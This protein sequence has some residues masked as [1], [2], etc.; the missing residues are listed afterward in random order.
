ML[1][2]IRRPV[3]NRPPSVF[4]ESRPSR[5][6]D[7]LIAHVSRLIDQLPDDVSCAWASFCVSVVSDPSLFCFETVLECRL[8]P[9][10]LQ[11]LSNDSAVTFLGYLLFVF[12]EAC[13][14]V[15][16][17][18]VVDDLM[19]LIETRSLIETD[20]NPLII[21]MVSDVKSMYFKTC[22]NI[23]YH[24]YTELSPQFLNR[25]VTRMAH[26]VLHFGMPSDIS[27]RQI[28]VRYKSMK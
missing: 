11:F 26:S 20:G 28:Y 5:P 19:T 1:A 14:S 24:I 12:P 15:I 27:I 7:K 16:S 21:D 6:A 4:E 23:S 18:S 13:A 9:I 3:Q 17:Q 22:S 2:R 25:A 8:M 10:P